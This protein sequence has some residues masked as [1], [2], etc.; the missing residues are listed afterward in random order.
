MANISQPPISETELSAYVDAESSPD[1]KATIEAW[2]ARNPAQAAKVRAW[3]RQNQALRAALGRAPPP[4][5]IKTFRPEAQSEEQTV[6]PLFAGSPNH[7][8][9]R[10]RWD[11]RDIMAAIAAGAFLAG[12]GVACLAGYWLG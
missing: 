1:R 7:A 12:A 10:A 6:T 11:R 2:L 9:R 8:P 3:R 5:T 4:M